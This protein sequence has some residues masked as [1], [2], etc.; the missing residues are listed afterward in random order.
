MRVLRAEFGSLEELRVLLAA[1]HKS[2]LNVS[3]KQR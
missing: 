2:I 3:R 1:G